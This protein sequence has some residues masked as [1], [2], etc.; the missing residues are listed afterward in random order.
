MTDFVTFPEVMVTA[1]RRLP[2]DID[3]LP[4]AVREIV[5]RLADEFDTERFTT[6]MATGGDQLFGAVV[7]DQQLDL[8]AAIPYPD[9]PLD[10][11]GG[12]HFGPRW[13]KQQVK[14]W[15]ILREYAEDTGGTVR[16]SKCNPRSPGERVA[17]L[18]ARNDWMLNNTQAVVAIW[19]P[20]NTVG[21]TYSCLRKAAGAGKPI[22]LVNLATQTITRPL[23][24]HWAQY[25][26]MPALAQH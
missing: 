7:K 3:W 8:R 23:P 16:V 19:A 14:D 22:I 12:D 9:Q 11:T 10:G 24:R 4:I 6:G 18:H 21:G 26:H 25:L 1:H 15:H 5:R 17:M 20:A 2:R 13:T